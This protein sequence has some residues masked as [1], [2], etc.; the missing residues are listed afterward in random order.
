[1]VYRV[2][3]PLGYDF[4]C[5]FHKW[6]KGMEPLFRDLQREVQDARDREEPLEEFRSRLSAAVEKKQAE[7]VEE[8]RSHYEM[9]RLWAEAITRDVKRELEQTIRKQPVEEVDELGAAS[10]VDH[11]KLDP[12]VTQ[13]HPRHQC[14]LSIRELF[15][16]LKK[17]QQREQ[18]LVE[19]EER[20]VAEV[21]EQCERRV[22]DLL[23]GW[24]QE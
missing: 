20:E 6:S 24:Y 23:Q 2:I 16:L 18:D 22:E 15:I 9:K 8:C 7:V 3:W 1:M 13:Y 21:Q 5:P 11:A 19:E 10:E 12:L 4:W 14:K 17:C